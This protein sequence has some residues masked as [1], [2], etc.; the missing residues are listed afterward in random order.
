MFQFFS[1]KVKE[2]KLWNLSLHE[3]NKNFI[4]INLIKYFKF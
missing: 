2:L 4:E 1:L 3:I